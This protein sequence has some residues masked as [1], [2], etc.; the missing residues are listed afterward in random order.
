MQNVAGIGLV[1]ALCALFMGAPSWLAGVGLPLPFEVRGG[2]VK[3]LADMAETGD[4]QICLDGDTNAGAT[5]SYDGNEG[6]LAY[7]DCV[8]VQARNVAI[9]AAED[10]PRE[11][12]VTGVYAIQ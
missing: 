9:R 6:M 2:A 8:M 10:S 12:V 4:V 5:I 3:Q 1:I 7:G 11:T